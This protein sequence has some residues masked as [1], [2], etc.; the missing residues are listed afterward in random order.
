VNGRFLSFFIIGG[1]VLIV[2]AALQIITRRSDP[3]TAGQRRGP[4]AAVVKAIFFAVV[5]VAAVLVGLGVIP[6]LRMR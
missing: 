2:S 1:V 3:A 5:G 4:D 6:L